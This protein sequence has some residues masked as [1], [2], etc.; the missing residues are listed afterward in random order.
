MNEIASFAREF[1]VFAALF[2]ALLL[3][4]LRTNS[5]REI[6]YQQTIDKNQTVIE[7]FADIIEIKIEA[8]EKVICEFVKKG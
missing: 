8:L 3:Y 2:T 7:K 4:V 6:M 5:Q 1:G